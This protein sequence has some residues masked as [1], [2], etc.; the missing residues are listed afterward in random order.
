MKITINGEKR[1]IPEDMDLGALLELLSMP[2]ER[3]AVELNRRVVKRSEWIAEK[4]SEDDRIEI[5]HFV[6][7]G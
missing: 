4:V 7:G 1:E 3:V 2:T 5:I 6:G